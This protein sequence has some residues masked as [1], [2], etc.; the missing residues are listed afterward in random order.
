MNFDHE[1]E[2]LYHPENFEQAMDED[3]NKLIILSEACDE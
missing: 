2:K 1:I 3:E